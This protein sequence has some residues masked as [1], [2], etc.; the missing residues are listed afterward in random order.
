MSTQQIGAQIGA[1]KSQIQTRI[2]RLRK[3]GKFPKGDVLTKQRT[4]SNIQVHD[5]HSLSEYKENVEKMAGRVPNPGQFV[6]EEAEEAEES[7]EEDRENVTEEDE[8]PARKR[9][10]GGRG[11]GDAT[12]RPA[13]VV[14][15]YRIL[16]TER[17]LFIILHE[18]PG[19]TTQLLPA[20]REVTV[21]YQVAPIPVAD[22]V[23]SEQ[24]DM[25]ILPENLQQLWSRQHL[26]DILSGDFVIPLPHLI[27]YDADF[28]RVQKGNGFKIYRFGIHGATKQDEAWL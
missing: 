8:T 24:G 1:S 27:T 10:D 11:H 25:E 12:D 3:E 14:L 21:R 20:E 13:Q 2:A 4:L 17:Y 6:A 19:V 18:W 9:G 5:L 16:H 15:P 22:L 28:A 26:D 7:E 23:D